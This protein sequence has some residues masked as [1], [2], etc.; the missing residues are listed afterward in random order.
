MTMIDYRRTETRI[1]C[2]APAGDQSQCEFFARSALK[3]RCR[4]YQFYSLRCERPG[5]YS[6][7]T[8]Y[9]TTEK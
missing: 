8:E 1:L 2:D 3:K 7:G 5:N 9:P 6:Q 4:H